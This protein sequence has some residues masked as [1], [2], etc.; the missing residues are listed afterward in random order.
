MEPVEV[1]VKTVFPVFIGVLIFILIFRALRAIVG[2]T[3]S[4]P[5]VLRERRAGRLRAR[6]PGLSTANFV[7]GIIGAAIL[8]GVT[9][10]GFVISGDF[11]FLFLSLC[12][13]AMFA[14]LIAMR[15]G[16]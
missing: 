6:G 10:Y 3:L 11:L 14:A 2:A 15:S 8:A 7:R 12:A 16:R 5:Q 13:L 4:L 1:I 9:L